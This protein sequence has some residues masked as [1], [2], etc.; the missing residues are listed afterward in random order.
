MDFLL[1]IHF[2]IL[3]D[4]KF[5]WFDYNFYMCIQTEQNVLLLF[6]VQCTG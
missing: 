5:R 4:K 3:K 2:V 6:S 1:C